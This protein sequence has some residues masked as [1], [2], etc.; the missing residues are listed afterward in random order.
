MVCAQ[1]AGCTGSSG[2]S[3]LE[4]IGSDSRTP[5]MS[6]TRTTAGEP[7][8]MRSRSAASHAS[9]IR[10]SAPIP[11]E[12]MKLSSGQVEDDHRGIVVVVDR[13]ERSFKDRR[14]GDV[15]FAGRDQAMYPLRALSTD[16]ERLRQVHEHLFERNVHVSSWPEP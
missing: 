16:L 5:V 14:R 9:F 7:L 10:I 4:I 8:T 13:L 1:S 12:S 11:V 6:S 3:V 2:S 15:Q